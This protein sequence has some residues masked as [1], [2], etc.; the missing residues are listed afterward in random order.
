MQGLIDDAVSHGA[1]V[2]A[3]GVMPQVTLERRGQF[4]PPTVLAGVTPA[5]RIWSEEVFGPVSVIAADGLGSVCT[6]P[7]LRSIG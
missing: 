4:Y 3:G 1:T 5:M 7:F 2:L 6:S